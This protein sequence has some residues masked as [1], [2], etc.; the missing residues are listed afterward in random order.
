MGNFST[1]LKPKPQQGASKASSSSAAPISTHTKEDEIVESV[2]ASVERLEIK[3]PVVFQA[4]PAEE[5]N[6]KI[7]ISEPVI[8]PTRFEE[9]LIVQKAEEKPVMEEFSIAGQ[10]L[11]L[12]TAADVAEYVNTLST[13]TGVKAVDLSGNTLGL[14]ACEA[15]A[16]ALSTQEDLCKVNIS[17]CFT[18]R[19]KEDVPPAIEIFGQALVDKKQLRIVDFSDNAF[20]P[21]GAKALSNF[22]SCC[23]NLEELRLNNNGLGPE[24][25][26][27]IAQALIKSRAKSR[28][29]GVESCL[30]K[31]TIGRNRL[32]N[33]SASM[34]AEAFK[35]HEGLQEVYMYQ[36]G[37]RPEGIAML[38][39]GLSACKDLRVIDLQDNT[40]TEVG[41]SAIASAILSW[42]HLTRL[43]IGDCLVSDEGCKLLISNLLASPSAA[44][45]QV[46]NFQYAEMESATAMYLAENL[47]KF[48]SLRSLMLNGNCFSSKGKE[49]EAIEA[50]L[51]AISADAVLDDLDEMDYESEE[52]MD[53]IAKD[54]EDDEADEQTLQEKKDDEQTLEEG[55][56]DEQTLEEKKDNE[57]T[58]EEKNDDDQSLE[59]KGADEQIPGNN[60]SDE[61][62]LEENQICPMVLISD[63]EIKVD[64]SVIEV[65]EKPVDEN[66]IF[67]ATE[68]A[69]FTEETKHVE[70]ASQNAEISQ[71]EELVVETDAM[72]TSEEPIIEKLA[73]EKSIKDLN[74][75]NSNEE[76]VAQCTDPAKE[77]TDSLNSKEESVGQE[78][79]DLVKITETIQTVTLEEKNNN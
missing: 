46:I 8:E 57:Q 13:V 55:R 41:A 11:R 29:A 73:V 75:L 59:E 20:S 62:I 56:A 4:K 22:L 65:E 67:E 30:R 6:P 49:F 43:M 66:P 74:A 52:E 26:K 9:V 38:A 21:A 35:A 71:I 5:I 64:D 68:A 54:M 58:L 50:A 51:M 77:P 76:P 53:E 36:N 72:T 3:E 17:D 48:S 12:N 15:L 18:G 42:S 28:E 37:I 33:G 44:T 61:Q 70:P 60:E 7:T 19:M 27:I 14:E 2:T 32:E 25:G 78:P 34:F 16:A 10:K 47:H 1:T 79:A 63:D 69:A 24:G 40:F 39:E 23:I 45:V 31:I